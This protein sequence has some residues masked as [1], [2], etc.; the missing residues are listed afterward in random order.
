[1]KNDDRPYDPA[2][3][4][5]CYFGGLVVLEFLEEDNYSIAHH[6]AEGS[7][8]MEFIKNSLSHNVWQVRCKA[9][10]A[11]KAIESVKD[12]IGK[13]LILNNIQSLNLSCQ[14][15]IEWLNY[16]DMGSEV[17]NCIDGYILGNGVYTIDNLLRN[18][19]PLFLQWQNSNW[20]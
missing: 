13:C 7:D 3:N 18:T 5:N 8:N 4:V 9:D 1:M 16:K 10:N 19:Q 14:L 15:S 20:R 17:E 11:S 6:I 2:E 12:F